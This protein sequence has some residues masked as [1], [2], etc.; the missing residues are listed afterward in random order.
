MKKLLRLFGNT[1]LKN[2]KGRTVAYAV[3]FEPRFYILGDY[4]QL[5][6][7][8]DVFSSMD[9]ICRAVEKF[10]QYGDVLFEGILLSILTQPWIKLAND[11]PQAEFIF[12][13]LN[14][15]LE[16]CLERRGERWKKEGHTRSFNPDNMTEKFYAVQKAHKR[17]EL[18]GLDTR[19]L[20]YRYPNQTIVNWLLEG[21][22]ANKEQG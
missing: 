11:M 6:G 15:P 22:F 16:V 3:H 21:R 8:C 2:K 13:T 17:L 20:D 4:N 18:A 5:L 1:E 19:W 7:G 10:S 12:A 9:A 14:T